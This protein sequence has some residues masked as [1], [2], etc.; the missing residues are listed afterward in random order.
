MG[1]TMWCKRS[2]A[3]TLAARSLAVL[4]LHGG[5]SL[6]LASEPAFDA[7]AIRVDMTIKAGQFH[8]SPVSMP[9]GRPVALVFHN[10]DAELHAFVPG[11]FLEDV[12]LHLDGNGT[13]QFGEKDWSGCRFH[14][15]AER[16]FALSRPC[17]AHSSTAVICRGIR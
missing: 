12:P 17:S 15:E 13:P 3:S 7:Q 5:H 14:R 6:V 11:R 16:T 2:L 4:W 10:L 1:A 9:V 8:P